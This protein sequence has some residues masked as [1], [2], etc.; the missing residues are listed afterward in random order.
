MTTPRV[1]ESAINKNW[2]THDKVNGITSVIRFV[3]KNSD[4]NYIVA[5]ARGFKSPHDKMFSRPAGRKSAL[6]RMQTF[7]HDKY[8]RNSKVKRKGFSVEVKVPYNDNSKD[9]HRKNVVAFVIGEENML[10]MHELE[11]WSNVILP[12][13][14]HHLNSTEG[15]Y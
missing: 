1:A 15:L 10:N 14:E 7:F 13:I 3:S 11:V 8:L 2:I 4:G 9:R 12:A 5:I 6:G